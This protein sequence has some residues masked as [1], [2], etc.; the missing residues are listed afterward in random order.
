MPEK[1]SFIK[2]H[3]SVKSM[4]APFVSYADLESLLKRMD[5]CINNPDKSS[6][7]QINKHEMCGYSLITHC[8]FDEK[9]NVVDYY[10]RK[11]CLKKFSQ[12]LK[13]QSKLIVDCEKKEM[14]K[15]T[16]D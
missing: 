11:D 13:K 8:S 4:R 12:D 1:D 16:V 9:K 14:I 7:K 2:Y 3:P 15:L 6:T 5:M 10:R